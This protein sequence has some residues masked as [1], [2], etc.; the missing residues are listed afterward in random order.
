MKKRMIG[1]LLAVSLVMTACGTSVS[2]STEADNVTE[3]GEEQKAD[4]EKEQEAPEPQEESGSE[5]EAVE[6]ASETGGG[7]PWID[8]SLKENITEGMET[9]PKDD[10]RLYVDYDWLLDAE[11]PAGERR[12][13]AFT[14]V[15][16]ETRD[17]AQALFDDETP[18]GY[19]AELVKYVYDACLDWDT[20]DELGMEPV[21]DTVDKIKEA[22]NLEALSGLLGNPDEDSFLP[23]FLTVQVVPGFDDATVN[24]TN[25]FGDDFLLEDAA[26]YETRTAMGDNYYEANKKAAVALLIRT[27]YGQE[28]AEELFD[29]AIGLEA[30]L[31][32]VSFT[33]ADKMSPDIFEKVNNSMTFS[34]LTALCENY[35]MADRLKA[36]GVDGTKQFVVDEPEYIKRLDD[37]YTEEN[38]EAIKG[39]MLVRYLLNTAD[40][41]DRE[42]YGLSVE[43]TNMIS[44]S[45][46]QV[47]DEQ[48]AYNVISDAMPEV[49][50]HAYVE[51]YDASKMKEDITELCEEI[52]SYYKQMLAE[53]DWLSEETRAQAVEKLD[54]LIVKAV[55][56][57]EWYDYSRLSLDGLSFRECRDAIKKYEWEKQ[58]KK[59]NQKVDR[60]GWDV[61]FLL[62]NSSYNPTDNSM[63]IYLG[64]LGGEFYREDM[65]QEEI[66]AGIGTVI[67]H[68]ISHAFDTMGSQ[69]DKEGNLASWW[70]GE[71]YNAFMERAGRLAAYYDGIT[72]YGDVHVAGENI[73]SEAI[74]DM[75]GVKCLLA[76]ASEKENFDYDAFFR[77]YARLYK[78]I[79]TAAWE[80]FLLTQDTHPLSYLRV[81]VSLQQFDEF[82]DTYDIKPGDN[83]YLAEEDRILVW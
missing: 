67:G 31:A 34:E 2:V 28:E 36:K 22:E 44:G 70:T 55:Y 35:P 81:N 11:I 60:S 4:S 5:E 21:M 54:N 3:T 8:S 20:R 32:E 76:I 56:P 43:R 75:S 29:A 62:A 57:D 47:P 80:N 19:E 53:E 71:D 1:L 15:A 27:G 51:K 39:Y 41:L 63:L 6:E 18:E 42:A 16:Q 13:T 82:N 78:A 30:E 46:G 69:F 52:I 77:Q 33:S 49:L 17:K 38:L 7:S 66:Y 72:V 58:T 48:Y 12:I 40:Q 24:I 10:F 9:S 23:D 73:M 79:N 74:A 65:T 26:E 37:I 25:V 14:E 83:M 45:A 59:V 61:N 68:E 64:I 50:G